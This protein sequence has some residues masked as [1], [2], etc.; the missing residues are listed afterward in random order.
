LRRP[1]FNLFLTLAIALIAI[2]DA[3]ADAPATQASNLIRTSRQ[4]SGATGSGSLDT[5]RVLGALLLV[6]GAIWA[7]RW[8][9]RR[10]MRLQGAGSNELIKV[11][12]R[13]MISPKRSIL[14]VQVAQRVL[15]VADSG[16]Q[17]NTLC[18][19]T[20]PDEIRA[21]NG[22]SSG[23]IKPAFESVLREEMSRQETDDDAESSLTDLPQS[24]PAKDAGL[25]STRREVH[26]LLEKVRGLSQQFRGA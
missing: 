15:I 9:M 4:S 21:F 25:S 23:P 7:C 11:L 24:V 17:L 18:Q 2:A 20:D 6:L 13:T 5:F 22:G 8:L 10:L 1:N 12:S 14:A 19:I 16:Q 26:T 3:R